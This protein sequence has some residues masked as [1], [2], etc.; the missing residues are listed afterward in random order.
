MTDNI[1][2]NKDQG[3]YTIKNDPKFDSSFNLYS[4]TK[5]PLPIVTVSLR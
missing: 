3:N 2:T 1:K 4:G 5:Y